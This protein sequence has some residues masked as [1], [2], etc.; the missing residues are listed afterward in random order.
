M[1]DIALPV[2][3]LAHVLNP[4]R[5][6]RALPEGP[7]VTLST[8]HP[9]EIA[10]VIAARGKASALAAAVKKDLG[11]ALPGMGQSASARGLALVGVQP[12]SWLAVQ[13]GGQ[14]LANRLETK[15]G[16]LAMVT[17]LSHGRTAMRIAG[18]RARDVL[19]KGT[20]VDLHRE[21]FKPG[22]AAATQIGHV[23]VT[24]IC[25][26]ADSFDLITLSTFAAGFWDGLCEL[27][28]EWGY[29]VR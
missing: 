20:A 19:S 5:Y 28:L 8:V 6:G 17:S 11:L 12:D 14:A 29:E 25:T 16:K 10:S 4:G 18:P 1:P 9:C 3:P 7:G 27:S 21:V 2:S 22:M 23:G 13:P 24:I 15:L 26:G